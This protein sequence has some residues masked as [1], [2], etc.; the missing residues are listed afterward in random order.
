MIKMLTYLRVKLIQTNVASI[1]LEYFA[2][3]KFF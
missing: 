3:A 1:Q 2:S